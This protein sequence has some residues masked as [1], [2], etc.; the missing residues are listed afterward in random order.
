MLSSAQLEQARRL[1]AARIAAARAHPAALCAYVVKTDAG[2]PAIPSRCHVEWLTLALHHRRVNL[3]APPEVAKSRFLACGYLLW[4]LGTDP[5]AHILMAAATA[6]P[7]YKNV[8]LIRHYIERSEELHEVFELV[9]SE[10][11]APPVSVC[12]GER[13]VL[14][15][16]VFPYACVVV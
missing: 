9:P 2:E 12:R 16:E 5:R 10:E 13:A 6:A 11:M 3:L 15:R 1:R 8:A 7:A 4:V 14:F